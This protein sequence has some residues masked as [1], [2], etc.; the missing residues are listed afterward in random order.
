M[1]NFLNT[2]REIGK[3]PT[4]IFGV[5]VVLALIIVAVVVIIKIPYDQ[6]IS[7]WR[8]GESIVYKNPRNVP[9]KWY[10]W[11]RAE[12]L[13]ESFDMKE[14][15]EGVSSVTTVTE[16]GTTITTFTFEFDHS[17]T[18]FPQDMVL[19][20]NSEYE[21]QQPFVAIKLFTPDERE[22]KIASFAL[23]KS[24]TYPML[25]DQKLQK[26]LNNVVPNI[27]LFL[28]PD[29]EEQIP[30]QGTYRLEIQAT[31]FESNSV[32]HPEFVLHGQVFGWA[33]T[34]HMRRD[35]SLP[36]LWGIPIALSFGL[37]AALGTSL[38]TMII[39]AFGTWYGGFWDALIQ[40]ITEV[41]MVLPFLSILIMVGTFYSRSIWTIL[42]AT[43]ALSIFTGGIKSY[44]AMFT[45]VKE[46]TYIEAAR[47][48]G[49][50]DGRIIFKYLIPRM[51]PLLLP[52]LI[53]A[54]PS[55]VFLEASL[56]LLGIGD[57]VLPT[58]GKMINEAYGNAALYR[59]WYY[60]ILEPAVLL[61]ITGLGFASLGFALDRIFNP[62][63]R[64][65]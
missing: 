45:Q 2:L 28:D 6:A 51:I 54:V 40:R 43:I 1:K 62:R 65:V 21:T 52:G 4:A 36:L 47:S 22:I 7:T 38:L 5:I 59:G 42:G 10:N 64:G 9:P 55:F 57:P 48:Y 29:V 53:S 32:V 60:W 30:V 50:G 26:R 12:K 63:L 17:Y 39:A 18:S 11:F 46:S 56:A 31:I 33:G 16:G 13:V 3:Y 14:G 20:F 19:Y 37:L 61:M 41:N 24:H 8:G 58:W 49:A 25:Q 35:L 23:T 27:G 15:D 44:R 34:D